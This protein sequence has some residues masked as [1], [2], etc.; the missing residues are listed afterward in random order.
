MG[1][2]YSK[3]GKFF[4]QLELSQSLEDDNYLYVVKNIS[5]L[6]GEG[7]ISRTNNGLKS[8]KE[9]KYKRRNRLVTLLD[10]K[11]IEYDNNEW[12]VI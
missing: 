6:L 1:S 9:K 7:A 2:N 11:V 8:D 5:K 4:A 3:L 10:S 12:M